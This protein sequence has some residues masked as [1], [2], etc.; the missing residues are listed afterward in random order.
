MFREFLGQAVAENHFEGLEV[1]VLGMGCAQ[2]DRLEQE[3][4]SAKERDH[5]YQGTG[6]R[7]PEV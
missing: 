4:L 5:G 7:L 1:K 6:P 2:C 3:V